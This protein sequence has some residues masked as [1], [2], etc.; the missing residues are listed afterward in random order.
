MCLLWQKRGNL[1]TRTQGYFLHQFE[2]SG[3]L[4]KGLVPERLRQVLLADFTVVYAAG[5]ALQAFIGR[6]YR[7]A[8]INLA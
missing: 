5:A 3:R 4:F 6:A 7:R 1:S 8:D 2:F